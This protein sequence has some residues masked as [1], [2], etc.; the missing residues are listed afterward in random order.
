MLADDISRHLFNRRMNY[1]GARM[2]QGRVLVDAD[3]NEAAM[4]ESADRRLTVMETVCTGGSPNDGFRVD[5]ASPAPAKLDLYP[6][7]GKTIPT[8]NNTYDFTLLAGSFYLAG[9]RFEINDNTHFLTQPNWPA[10]ALANT[11]NIPPAVTAART[12]VVYVEGWEETVSSTEDPEFREQAL[13]GPDTTTRLRRNWRVRVVPNARAADCTAGAAAMRAAMVARLTGLTA[14][15][16]Q[17]FDAARATFVSKGRLKMA[18]SAT[19]PNTDPCKPASISGFIGAENVTIRVQQTTHN[20]FIWGIDDAGPLFRVK[21]DPADAT[22]L[23]FI[24]TPRDEASFPLSGQ[25]V[26]LL[27]WGAKL[28]NGSIAAEATGKLFT[29]AAD[30][31]SSDRSLKLSQ[32]V[33]Q[34]WRDWLA[35]QSGAPDKYFYL[36]LWTGGSGNAV[37]PDYAYTVGT[38]VALAGTGLEVTFLA[39]AADGDYW[40]AAARPNTP[41][42]LVPWALSNGAPPAGPV[43]HAAALGL[44]RWTMSGGTV[45]HTVSDCRDR[46]RSLCSIGTCCTVTVGDGVNSFGDTNDLA[47]AV[48]M[49]PPEGGELCLLRGQHKGPLHLYNRN[50]VT[51]HGCGKLTEILPPATTGP[52]VAIHG[53]HDVAIRSLSITA[54]QNVAIEAREVV[55]LRLETLALNARDTAA[56]N[57]R[58][59]IGLTIVQCSIRSTAL[60]HNIQSGATPLV[61]VQGKSLVIES[62]LISAAGS[63][64]L[65]RALGGLQLGGASEDVIIRDNR[66]IGG[67]GDGILLGSMH[68]VAADIASDPGKL[69]NFIEKQGH[70]IF[71]WNATLTPLGCID[72]WPVPRPPTTG[73]KPTQVPVTDGPIWRLVI[74][75]NLIEDMGGN[76]ISCIPMD[77]AI[78]TGKQVL[79][80]PL[81]EVNDVLIVGNEI[82]SC[83]TLPI[84]TIPAGLEDTL[85]RGGILLARTQNPSIVANTVEDC[86]TTHDGAVCGIF[87]AA[88]IGI[89]IEDNTVRHNGRP[90]SD[91]NVLR[92]GIRG[93]IYVMLALQRPADNTPQAVHLDVS[94][95]AAAI[96]HRNRVSAISA[97]ALTVLAA[98]PVQVDDNNFGV[99]GL[100]TGTTALQPTNGL[101]LIRRADLT[102]L[103]AEPNAAGATAQAGG[104][105]ATRRAE[106][107]EASDAT[108]SDR[109]LINKIQFQAQFVST[110]QVDNP[111]LL[112]LPLL[113]DL[114]GAASVFVFDLVARPD[115]ASDIRN[116]TNATGLAV[117]RAPDPTTSTW[118]G[119]F[120]NVAFNDNIVSLIAQSLVT[121]GAAPSGFTQQI[122]QPKAV[123]FNVALISYDDVGSDSNHIACVNRLPMIANLFTAASTV[124]ANSNRLTEPTAANTILSALTVGDIANATALNQADHCISD[125]ILNSSFEKTGRPHILG[126][127]TPAT[128]Q[129]NAQH[130][131]LSNAEKVCDGARGTGRED[132]N[133]FAWLIWVIEVTGIVYARYQLS[134]QS[135][136][137]TLTVLNDALVKA[138]TT[139][140]NTATNNA[141][142]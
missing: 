95:P 36:R 139:T 134:N 42:V 61:F 69:K 140:G 30:Y 138:A 7:A 109:I 37:N 84:E 6:D 58:T 130:V 121:G 70:A 63:P 116:P 115:V 82:R 18:P 31:D 114:F 24:T 88:G 107:A 13:G 127:S 2:Q 57:V 25:A 72:W 43:R 53:C 75:N 1:S 71:V 66:I 48:A 101:A 73:G 98:G 87:I 78:Q 111:P 47:A 136:A 99:T 4:L 81:G 9:L 17:W 131:A 59:T 50:N 29:I 97:R 104:S 20:R 41:N 74:A 51:V 89:V 90:R 56:I 46:F 33:P 68:L 112:T 142:K 64:V 106:V 67:N 32:P 23:L 3:W 27:P 12:D 123:G 129:L 28:D 21:V 26:E 141:N 100:D 77:L 103:R 132:Y 117:G 83:V 119:A 80:S 86:A 44:I 128:L 76:G 40:I 125:V 55:G 120:G 96:V 22:R 54:P 126:L 10:I 16:D 11:P 35:D 15:A 45:Q 38:P 8:V 113:F 91:T 62:N 92:N 34:G 93:G 102:N 94:A 52:V 122:A 118:Q 5:P 19:A 137:Q 135:T 133:G 79:G 105:D 65:R 49:L 108:V 110:L 14:N 60:G 39:A 85:V 124:R